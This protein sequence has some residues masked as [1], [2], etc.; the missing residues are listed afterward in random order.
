[1][2]FSLT[3]N[4]TSARSAAA[5]AHPEPQPRDAVAEAE[6]QLDALKQSFGG[7]STE[8]GRIEMEIKSSTEELRVVRGAAE[9]ERAKLRRSCGPDDP[10]TGLLKQVSADIPGLEKR[11]TNLSGELESLKP[12][13]PPKIVSTRKALAEADAA[14]RKEFESHLGRAFEAVKRLKD[15]A[16][17]F[18]ALTKRYS[19]I[20]Q[21]YKFQS[22]DDASYVKKP[23]YTGSPVWRTAYVQW[24]RKNPEL[25]KAPA[26]QWLDSL[27]LL[28][29]KTIEKL[30]H[31]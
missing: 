7:V 3:R 26:R 10:S 29:V 1:M 9:G 24:R 28:V 18:E 2:K 8:L 12:T 14:D 5:V 21:H 16:E 20:V 19:A 13:L 11:I 27:N 4:P 31:I 23:P 25:E 30:L 22:L 15:R 17:Q 6:Q